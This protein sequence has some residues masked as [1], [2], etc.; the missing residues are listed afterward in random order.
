MPDE[1]FKIST[2]KLKTM[3]LVSASETFLKPGLTEAPLK[4]PT[5]TPVGA[6]LL[7]P[8]SPSPKLGEGERGGEGT[9][10]PA[11]LPTAPA[12]NPFQDLPFP[13]PGDRIKAD[14]FKKLS[15]SLKILYEMFLLSGTLFG[16]SF[17]EARLVLIAQQ[18]EIYKVLTVFGTEIENLNDTS[19]D[20]RK[21]LQVMP[22]IPGERRVIVILTEAVETRRFAPN[23]LGLTYR[24]ASE[25][26]RGIL[27]DITFP[28]T[29]MNVSQ[30]VGLSLTEA[31]QILSK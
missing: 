19:L 25:R 14:D 3:K 20:N 15:Q 22:V 4:S 12:S 31:K 16:H 9:K 29:P 17:K 30:L 5:E 21:V 6:T 11:P 1:K 24:E 7:H 27:G 2:E 13:S 23:L 28:A 18:Y 26:L 10:P 8:P